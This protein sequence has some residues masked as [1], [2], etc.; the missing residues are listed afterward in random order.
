MEHLKKNCRGKISS[1]PNSSQHPINSYWIIC[2]MMS[3]VTG[4]EFF[5]K[6]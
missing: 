4:V 2:S 5:D 6:T 3:F 1:P